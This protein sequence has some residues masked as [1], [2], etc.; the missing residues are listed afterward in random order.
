MVT[1]WIRAASETTQE[2]PGL[3]DGAGSA[4]GVYQL[5][6]RPSLRAG[7]SSLGAYGRQRGHPALALT[8]NTLGHC[9]EG[10]RQ[11]L[12]SREQDTG[13]VDFPRHILSHGSC[14]SCR[15]ADSC[16]RV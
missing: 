11:D 10:R 12:L 2:P 1:S 6:Q 8:Q 3:F 4:G 7:R 13:R 16:R 9:L 14:G 15:T 5:L